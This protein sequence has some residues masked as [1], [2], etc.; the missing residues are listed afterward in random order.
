LRA[1]IAGTLVYN[2]HIESG[3]STALRQHQLQEVLA[4]QAR[5]ATRG[6]VIVGGDF[7]NTLAGRLAVLEAMKAAGLA[8]PPGTDQGQTSIRRRQPIDWIFEKGNGRAEGHIEHAANISDQ[9]PV[10]ATLTHSD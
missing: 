8:H 7:N 10:V 3:G 6:T 9:Y 1:R 5:V 2:L 4:D